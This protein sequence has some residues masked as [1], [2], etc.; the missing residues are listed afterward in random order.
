MRVQEFH[1]QLIATCGK[2]RVSTA[3][4]LLMIHAS[5]SSFVEGVSPSH[6][7]WPSNKKQIEKILQ[8]A[9][10]FKYHVIPISSRLTNRLHGDTLPRKENTLILD[11]SNFK[12][13]IKIDKKN[14]VVMIEPGV[15]FK[16]L[17]PIL[18]EKGLQLL[19]PLHPRD[20]KSVVTAAL[21]RVPITIPRYQWDSSDP[22]L[23]TEVI[24]GTGDLFRTGTAA[25]PGTIK[26]QWKG[27][28]AQVNPMGPTHFSP[29]RILQGA[30]GSMGIVMWATM[31]LELIPYKQKVFH[32]HSEDLHS[33]LALQQELIKYRLCDEIFILNDLALASLVK[34]EPQEIKELADI[35]GKWN[36][37]YII[38]GRGGLADDRL[39][40][41]EGDITDLMQDLDLKN[42]KC[43]DLIEEKEIIHCTSES[44]PLPWR[45]RYKGSFQDIYFLTLFE[46]LPEHVELVEKLVGQEVEVG[47]YIQAINQGT[48]Y[49]C[50]FDLFHDPMEGNKLSRVKQ[51]FLTIGQQLIK[52]G[53]FFNRPHGLLAKMIFEN[54][55]EE[56]IRALKKVKN[57][58]DPNN[59]LNPGVLCFDD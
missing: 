54:Y 2:K 44:T 28:Q 33:L 25:G 23:C 48:A 58:F 27:G 8:L 53:A 31:K 41:L 59:I 6:V 50:E 36:L 7:V 22:L 30:Q 15:T 20:N 26:E 12:K 13:V 11:L 18:K 9:N 5:D 14:R 49:H 40:Y 52:Q 10:D 19:L 4:S 39:A 55:S 56:T 34:K 42:V 29:F 24:F 45:A 43:E 38:S 47:T 51:L 57:I 17:I 16:Q 1:E 32:Y 3:N 46:K 21:D 37:I 35:L